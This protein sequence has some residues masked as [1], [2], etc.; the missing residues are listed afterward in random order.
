MEATTGDKEKLNSMKIELKFV[1]VPI[2]KLDV[3]DRQIVRTR[4]K[5]MN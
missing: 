4:N 1:G 2:F 5:K 3:E